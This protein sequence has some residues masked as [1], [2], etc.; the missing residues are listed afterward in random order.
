MEKMRVL[1]TGPEGF[2]GKEVLDYFGKHHVIVHPERFDVTDEKW[3]SSILTMYDVDAV[4][5]TA[6]RGGK[7]GDDDS[8]QDLVDNVTMFNNLIKH[9]DKYEML[10]CFCSGAAFNRDTPID[11]VSEEDVV[12]NFPTDYYGMSKN[13]L[14]REVLKHENVFNMRLFGCFGR[15]EEKSR[16][17]SNA[18]TGMKSNE[19]IEVHQNRKMDF[20]WAQDV[21]RVIDFYMQH[22]RDREL[23]K[24]INLTYD[25]DTTLEEM[26]RLFQT[27]RRCF[28]GI[29]TYRAGMAAPYSGNGAKLKELGVDKF[30]GLARGLKECFDE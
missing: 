12:N 3:L 7:R 2:L 1:V 23:P 14:A 16:F 8:L 17:F 20:F 25:T 28:V 22:V 18:L 15:H 4:I 10:F 9:K 11:N 27:L 24:D 30:F 29:D 13:I 26:A 6:S 19:P 5:H 21:C